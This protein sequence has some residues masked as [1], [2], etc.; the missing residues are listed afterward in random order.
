MSV[1]ASVQVRSVLTVFGNGK[2][3]RANPVVDAVD[4]TSGSRAANIDHQERRGQSSPVADPGRYERGSGQV[5]TAGPTSP[6][7]RPLAP[8]I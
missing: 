1:G 2:A 5:P 3:R 6:L 7:A 8:L 4:S